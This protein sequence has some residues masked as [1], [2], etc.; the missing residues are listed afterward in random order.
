MCKWNLM[1]ITEL[2]LCIREL[3]IRGRGIFK[4]YLSKF[5]RDT[6][7]YMKLCVV[8]FLIIEVWIFR[9]KKNSI[10]EAMELR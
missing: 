5:V 2:F 1:R 9:K 10:T 8:I 7:N 4:M 6:L 3:L